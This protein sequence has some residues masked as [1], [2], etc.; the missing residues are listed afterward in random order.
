MPCAGLLPE[1][2]KSYATDMSA[3]GAASWE[4]SLLTY[5]WGLGLCLYSLCQNCWCAPIYLANTLVL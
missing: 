4:F 2:A 3:K 5:G 1:I